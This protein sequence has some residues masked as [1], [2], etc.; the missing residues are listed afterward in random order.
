MKG[1]KLRYFLRFFWVAKSLSSVFLG[2]A[3]GMVVS[4]LNLLLLLVGHGVTMGEW[5]PP[6]CSLAVMFHFH[7]P[8]DKKKTTSHHLATKT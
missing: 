1:E 3:V 2:W 5:I 6:R 4:S 7:D 8:R